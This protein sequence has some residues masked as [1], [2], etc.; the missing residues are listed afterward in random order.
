[1]VNNLTEERVNSMTEQEL[2]EKRKWLFAEN[3]RIKELAKNLEDE[4]KLIEIQKGILEK[5]QRKNMLLSKQLE[6]QKKK[7]SQLKRLIMLKKK[8]K[9]M[10]RLIMSKKKIS[11]L[12]LLKKKVNLLKKL[13]KMKIN[14]MKMNLKKK[15]N[16]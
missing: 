12:K 10:K 14:Q 3:I 6:N 8:I 5:K 11:Q 2:D 15:K 9:L 1:M 13:L 7:I 16:L 4:R